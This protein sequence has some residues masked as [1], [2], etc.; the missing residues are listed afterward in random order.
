MTK[1]LML[2]GIL[3]MAGI[4]SADS[5]IYGNGQ[6]LVKVNESGVFYFHS[7]HLGSTSVITNSKG[8]V[9]EEQINLPFGEPI[10]GSERYGFTGKE[11]D[12]DLGLNYFGARYY[13][14][15]TGRFL[16]VDPALQDFSSYVYT[17]NNPLIRIDPDGNEWR[18]EDWKAVGLPGAKDGVGRI[19]F[20]VSF[21]NPAGDIVETLTEK[22]SIPAYVVLVGLSLAP[23]PV[24]PFKKAG[25][26]IKPVVKKAFF[27]FAGH[28]RRF[29]I[30]KQMMNLYNKGFKTSVT[31]VWLATWVYANGDKVIE[32]KNVAKVLQMHV[33]EITDVYAK[34]PFKKLKGKEFKPLFEIKDLLPQLQDDVKILLQSSDPKQL[35]KSAEKIGELCQEIGVHADEYRRIRY[36]LIKALPPEYDDALEKAYKKMM[37][38]KF[39]YKGETPIQQIKAE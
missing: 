21:V 9:V 31:N 20:M 6:R 22:H 1:I 27:F 13:S 34:I 10:S 3:L 38:N 32:G 16:N 7:D 15:E 19:G 24:S 30:V 12:S 4:A 33:D 28:S 17:G 35:Q 2:L 26:T 18:Y 39:H 37:P 5:Y 29:K 25:K 8:E 11:L 23:G 14:P 36:D